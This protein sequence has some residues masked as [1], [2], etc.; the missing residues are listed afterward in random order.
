MH[1]LLSCFLFFFFPPLYFFNQV[2]SLFALQILSTL[3]VSPQKPPMPSPSPASKK[4]L[5]YPPTHSHILILPF[6]YTGVSSATYAARAMCTPWE[7][8]WVWLVDILGLP[9]G[10]QSPLPL[11]VFWGPCAQS[12]G[13]LQA[14]T[15]V[16]LRP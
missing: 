11:L 2:F 10:L 7:L 5:L 15:T 16:F 6:P 3:P 8:W 9:M 13:W 14:F 1:S 12:N 4:V